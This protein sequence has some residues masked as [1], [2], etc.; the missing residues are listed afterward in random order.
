VLVD[1]KL[2]NSMQCQSAASKANRILSCIK[3]GMDS[4]GRDVI[5]PLYKALVRPQLEYAVQFWAPVN[6]KD[7][8]EL[9][10]VQRRA[11]KL[12]KG[13]EDLSYEQIK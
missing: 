2:N 4:L 7:A 12:I 5:L 6:K 9:E 13:L 3:R 10:K 8:L 1:H 11:T